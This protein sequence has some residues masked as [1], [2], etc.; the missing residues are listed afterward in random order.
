MDQ[1]FQK[2]YP[3]EACLSYEKIQELKKKYG[4]MQPK[5]V[6]YYNLQLNS[7]HFK[8]FQIIISNKTFN[9]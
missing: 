3:I 7:F 8:V 5:Q 6:V 4:K 1:T 2:N 9:I